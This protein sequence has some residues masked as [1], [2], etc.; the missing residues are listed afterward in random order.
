MSQWQVSESAK[1]HRGML[2][3]QMCY[4]RS[5][6]KIQMAKSAFTD[7]CWSWKFYVC[8]EEML[9]QSGIKYSPNFQNKTQNTYLIL[10]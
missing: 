2:K 9:L 5:R 4:V 8:I 1:Q 10:W 7:D 3:D 6:L